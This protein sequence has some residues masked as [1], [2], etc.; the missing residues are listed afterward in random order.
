M[1]ILVGL[2]NPGEKYSKTKHNLGFIIIDELANKLGLTWQFDKHFNAEVCRNGD[3]ILVKPQTYMNDSG[4]SIA[5]ILNYFK[6]TA[7]NL[8]I[9]H[10]D[11]D[12]P[13]GELRYKQG[14]GTAG[15]HGVED[16]R[17]K[18]NTLNFWRVRIGIGRPENGKFNVEDYVLTDFNRE[19][20]TRLKTE[21]FDKVTSFLKI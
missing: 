10:D 4:V 17:E 12:L 14:S 11:V 8:I 20:L 7:D 21:L 6:E 3:L 13:F 1:R 2:G 9:I 18:L 19:E 15:H 16:T 5:K